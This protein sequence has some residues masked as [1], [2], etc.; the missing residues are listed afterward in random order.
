VKNA[1]EVF[2][3]LKQRGLIRDYAIGGAIA[4]LRWTEPFFTQDLDIF[5]LLEKE[6]DEE[7]LIVLSPVYEYLRGKGYVWKGHW[8]VIEG[9][10]IDV[11]PADPLEREAVEQ[12]LAVE[13]EGVSTKVIIPEYLIALFLRA[14]RDK[15]WR[16]IQML[17]DQCE[18]DRERLQRILTQYGLDEKFRDFE[19]KWHG[20]GTEDRHR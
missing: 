19:E 4:A 20:S 17:L 16:K 2:N 9:V 8:I 5:V 3:E 7:G 14:G 1:L 12:A 13:Y 15:D 6:A 18:I 11:F 10:P